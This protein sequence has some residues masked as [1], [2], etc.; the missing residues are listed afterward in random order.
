MLYPQN[1]RRR[2]VQSL[3]GV[4][5]YQLVSEDFCAQKPLW[6]FGWMAVPASINEIV[7]DEALRDH[8]GK[9]AFETELDASLAD[10]TKKLLYI[11]SSGH[12]FEVYV[13]GVWLGESALGFLPAQFEL[14][15]EAFPKLRITVVI[16]NRLTFQTL[17]VG[18]LEDGK[19]QIKHD[20]ANDTG[21][22]R[23]VSVLTVPKD[24]I[25][26]LRIS[27][28]CEEDPK[29]VRV[30]T[31]GGGS[32]RL[33]VLD[34]TGACVAAGYTKNGAAELTVEEPNLWEPGN[35][36]LYRMLA[37]TEHDRYEQA[38][39]IR[40]VKVTDTEFLLNG[41]PLKLRGF[42][43]HEDHPIL[44]KG[45]NT[46]MNVRDFELLKWIG[47][48]CFRTSHYPYSDEIMD[49][50]DRYGILVIDEVPAVGMNWW[51]DSFTPERIN[52]ETAELHRQALERLWQRD[53]NH[54]SV[55]MFSVGN[56]AG[57]EEPNARGYFEP[58]IS[59]TKELTGLP[60]TL[61][62]FTKCE[63]TTIGDLVDVI[64]I[65]RYYGWYY[66]H[67]DLSVIHGQM[68]EELQRWR[69]R[70]GKPILITEYGAD[71]VEGLHSLPAESF[72][73]EF[74][75]RYLEEMGKAF[76]EC[77]WCIGDLVW[78]FADFRTKQGINRVR[79]NRKGVFTRDRRPKM[80][81]HFL[82]KRWSE[83]G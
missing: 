64:S 48:N 39:G 2:T 54:P 78:N 59:F 53:K 5:K 70:F 67:G 22:M 34:Q 23:D 62:E 20:F 17:P 82:K 71:T 51:E 49:L 27:T 30:R 25:E 35:P 36:Y 31:V 65:N 15:A 43:M 12:K 61:A 40:Q 47:A 24:C 21:I 16:D 42:G 52:G 69:D 50:A 58:L 7:T 9:V 26:D 32:V 83:R 29:L 46:A 28:Y 45:N 76:D 80:A 74:Q 10:G 68:R 14:P 4:W 37:E 75:V 56:E 13:N 11:G 77:P 44:G 72:S 79:G 18:R 57:T 38:F 1:N 73:E 60:V 66:D 19:Q 6:E 55:I 41:K 63:D 81:A 8:V 33:T 3:N